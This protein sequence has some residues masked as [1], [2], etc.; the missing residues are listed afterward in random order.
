MSVTVISHMLCAVEVIKDSDTI[1]LSKD[2][3]KFGR[4]KFICP[5]NEHMFRLTHQ[6]PTV[7][8]TSNVV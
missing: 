2:D 6:F 8:T 4:K 7:P 1:V 5:L 3:V